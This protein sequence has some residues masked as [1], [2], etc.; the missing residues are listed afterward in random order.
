MFLDNER[1]SDQEISLGKGEH[2]KKGSPE[3][4]C[5]Q[6][7]SLYVSIQYFKEAYFA[8]IGKQRTPQMPFT[9]AVESSSGFSMC[10]LKAQFV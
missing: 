5:C 7:N 10:S 2:K 6:L 4:C 3:R 8:G 9:H 1:Y